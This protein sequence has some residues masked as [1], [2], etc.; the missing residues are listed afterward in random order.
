VN[1]PADGL[2]YIESTIGPAPGR[3]KCA[4]VVAESPQAFGDEVSFTRKKDAKQYACKKAIDWLIKNN[5][6]PADG[7][8]FPKP[9]PA[10][11]V[12]AA[13][14]RLGKGPTGSPLTSTSTAFASQIPALCNL[15]GFT[16]PTYVITRV[17]E[18]A[19]LYSGYAHFNGDPR[20]DGKIGEVSEI[21]GQ[22]NAKEMIASELFSFL[23]DIERQQTQPVEDLIS[24][25]EGSEDGKV[26]AGVVKVEA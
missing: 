10:N 4:A 3:F 21:F 5:F 6:M 7:V 22:K 9:K 15:L 12:P 23:K 25:G 18:N 13:K 8:K 2:K 11:P 1:R 14:P 17:S 20:I 26:A 19:P 16:P 24:L